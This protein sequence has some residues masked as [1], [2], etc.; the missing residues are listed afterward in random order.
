MKNIFITGGSKGIG[1][2]T[3]LHF[4]D[5]G[6]FVGVTDV[7]KDALEDVKKELPEN[8]R[9][10]AV[11]DVTNAESVQQT[12]Q[13]F[14]ALNHGNLHVLLN[15][16]GVGWIEPFETMEIR[17]HQATI[18]VNNKGVIH[19]TYYAF[20]FLKATPGARVIS[21]CSASA[22]Y[23]IPIEVTYSA[24]KFFI[25]GMTEALNLEWKRYGIHVCDIMPNFVKTP[26]MATKSSAIVKNIGVKLTAEDVAKKIWMAA[27]RKKVHW[28]VEFFPYNI[29]QPITKYFP[30]WMTR[31][32]IRRKAEL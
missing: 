27:H 14:C 20:P 21:M 1:K 15:N 32:I 9:F 31:A 4:A 19:C 24:S 30:A 7:D 22:H 28:P 29:L 18:D 13:Q 3:A 5:Q 16:A 23:G 12:L 6:W 17:E 8:R 11:M 26:M 2:A 25:R 10:T